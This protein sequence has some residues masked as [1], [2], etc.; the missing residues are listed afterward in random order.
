M[1]RR[2]AAFVAGSFASGAGQFPASAGGYFGRDSAGSRQVRRVRA[3]LMARRG[4]GDALMTPDDAA[5]SRGTAPGHDRAA[6]EV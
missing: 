6:A 1:S 4:G 5:G 2:L 3:A